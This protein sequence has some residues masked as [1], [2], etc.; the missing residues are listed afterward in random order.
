MIESLRALHESACI[1][2][3]AMYGSQYQ[4]PNVVYHNNIMVQYMILSTPPG[5]SVPPCCIVSATILQLLPFFINSI[6]GLSL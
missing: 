6:N 5:T 3:I 4:M 2:D 1:E